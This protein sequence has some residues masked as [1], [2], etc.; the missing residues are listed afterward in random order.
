MLAEAHSQKSQHFHNKFISLFFFT[1]LFCSLWFQ[2]ESVQCS[3]WRTSPFLPTANILFSYDYERNIWT[4]NCNTAIRRTDNWTWLQPIIHNSSNYAISGFSYRF[5]ALSPI[6]YDF[7]L[8]N[9]QLDLRP[10]LRY[11]CS[12][13]H[14]IQ[15]PFRVSSANDHW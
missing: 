13:D 5:Y 15:I 9:R 1:I 4:R 12:L 11:L 7:S 10:L 3:L 6:K 14:R 8:S 2:P